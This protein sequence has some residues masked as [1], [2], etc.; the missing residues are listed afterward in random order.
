MVK[1]N[2]YNK[3]YSLLD[4]STDKFLQYMD[5]ILLCRTKSGKEFMSRLVS[6]EGNNL[7]FENKRGN[8][9]KNPV[10]SIVYFAEV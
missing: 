1:N 3:E 6:I 2:N 8:I 5:K 10:A 9:I 7:V 4:E